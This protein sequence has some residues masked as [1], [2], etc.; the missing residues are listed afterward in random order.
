MSWLNF[1][2]TT[3][4]QHHTFGRGINANISP[5]E[6]ELFLQSFQKFENGAILEAYEL[7]F[8]SLL[9]YTDEICNN[10][11]ILQKEEDTLHFTLLQ[12]CATITGVITQQNLYAEAIIVTK[13]FANVALKRYLLERNYQL[14]YANYFADE[15]MIKIKLYH[16]NITMSPQKVFFPLREIALNADFD[17]EY[18][19]SEFKDIVLPQTEH[20]TPLPQEELEIKYS[21]MQEEIS[22]VEAKILTLPSNDN[23]SMQSFLYLNLLF[24]IDYLIVPKQKIYQQLS[25]R[26]LDYFSEK[27]LPMEARNEELRRYIEK[28]KSLTLQEFSS[29]FY[30]A[31]Y[32]FN[33]TE[34]SNFEDVVAFINDSL[35][36]VRWYKNNR[37]AQ[38][39]PTIYR[40]IAFY[41]LYNYGLNPAAR[42]LLHILVEVQNGDFFE[43]LGYATLYDEEKNSFAK[44]TI[45][46]RINTIIDSYVAHY[47]A[48]ESFASELNFGSLNEF[49]NSFYLLFAN[50]NFEEI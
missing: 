13:E 40:Y 24:E 1:F 34:K 23:T 25:K 8:K 2:Q 27:E 14:T 48:L 21:F 47:P 49:S 46:S 15:E 41:I 45:I 26:I 42:E 12:G 5:N 7:F 44:R 3:H 17:R 43:R 16:D 36:K 20:L 39:I 9:N 32:T 28:L 4:K 10:N 22:R 50:L 18:L 6:E 29:N 11:I 31:K 38:I 35:G 19:K 33:P 37:Y 30:E